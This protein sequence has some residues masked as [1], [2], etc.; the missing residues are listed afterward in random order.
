MY[1]AVCMN[2]ITT[3]VL[4]W[5]VAVTSV[6]AAGLQRGKL[7]PCPESPNCVCSDEQGKHLI[8]PFKLKVAPEKAWAVLEQVLAETPRVKVVTRTDQ[9]LHAEF[10][11][12]MLHFVDDVELDLRPEAGIIAV[13]SASR[14][15]YYDFG[16]NRN[17]VEKLRE[18]LRG[19]GVIE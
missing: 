11:S 6:H 13:R 2:R 5:S 7:A 3:A 4:I 17:R 14:V 8:A 19:R 12:A 1:G 10:T 16:A 15:G 18:Q 9:Y